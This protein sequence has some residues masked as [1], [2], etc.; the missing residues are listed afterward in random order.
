MRALR[1]HHVLC[2]PLFVGEGYSDG[3]SRNMSE[4]KSWLNAHREEKLTIV[5][6][7]DEI[8]AHC[9]NLKTVSMDWQTLVC[10]DKGNQVQKKDEDLAEMLGLSCPIELSWRELL[11]CAVEKMNEERF[12]KSCG[13]CEWYER[14]LCNYQLW[15]ENAD[16]ILE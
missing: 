9:P 2:L 4:K 5:C 10:S 6:Q 13:R 15:R 1:V 7:P 16:R 3:F 14:G 8:C 11:N 12:L